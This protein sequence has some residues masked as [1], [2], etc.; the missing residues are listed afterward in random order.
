MEQI[1]FIWLTEYP[2][3][4]N[5]AIAGGL[6][7]AIA[8]LIVR[9]NKIAAPLTVGFVVLFN[10][11]FPTY[12]EKFV[13]D[14]A[15]IEATK[16]YPKNLGEYTTLQYAE[17]SGKTIVRHLKINRTLEDADAFIQAQMENFRNNGY[18]KWFNGVYDKGYVTEDHFL[19]SIDGQE[20]GITMN[21]ISCKKK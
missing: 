9:N 7:G 8:Y 10:N 12:A 2:R 20:V 1:I 3:W 19:Y 16:P 5:S 11:L 4:I 17:I 15:F 13:F 18:C 14:Y 6:F 21:S